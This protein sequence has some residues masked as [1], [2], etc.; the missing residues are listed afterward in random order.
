MRAALSPYPLRTRTN[1]SSLRSP[2]TLR[3]Q[4]RLAG[5]ERTSCATTL[6]E[7]GS[8]GGHFMFAPIRANGVD[9]G[10]RPWHRKILQPGILNSILYEAQVSFSD[11]ARRDVL[12]D[13]PGNRRERSDLR[14][15]RGCPG[16]TAV[17]LNTVDR[18][19]AGRRSG[20]F[21]CFSCCRRLERRRD[22]GRRVCQAF[23]RNPP[24]PSLE[25]YESL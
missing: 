10:R 15:S 2:V 16:E 17:P 20:S 12:L 13:I 11:H 9:D 8:P 21:E 18:A 19:S 22:D 25:R 24:H 1:C 23:N 6:L 3:L 14:Q 4:L 7:F 5:V